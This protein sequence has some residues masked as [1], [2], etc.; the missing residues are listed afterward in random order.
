MVPASKSRRTHTQ[1]LRQ[2]DVRT[3]R[4]SLDRGRLASPLGEGGSP[5]LAGVVCASSDDV[6][7]SGRAGGS[8]ISV[9]ATDKRGFLED[10]EIKLHALIFRLSTIFL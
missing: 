3:T 9:K 8:A 5:Q 6:A 10:P 7:G 1:S 4:G 2:L